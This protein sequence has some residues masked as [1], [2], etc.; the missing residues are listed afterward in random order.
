[1]FINAIITL[2]SSNT[3]IKR[4]NLYSIIRLFAYL[5]C[6]SQ[7]YIIDEIST[8]H[9]LFILNNST[10]LK[11]VHMIGTSLVRRVTRTMM[12]NPIQMRW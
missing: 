12:P 11:N 5:F 10:L 6:L 4:I 9:N 3:Y 1:M 7:P 8:I 2:K